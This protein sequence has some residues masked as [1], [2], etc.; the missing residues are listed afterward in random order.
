MSGSFDNPAG[1]AAALSVV[2]PFTLYFIA[3]KNSYSR[4]F[5]GLSA[6][7]IIAAVVLSQSR[8]GVMAL[9]VMCGIWMFAIINVGWLKKWSRKSRFL[10]FGIVAS[11]ILIG[12]YFIKKDSADG[13]LLIWKCTAHMISEKPIM[14][15]GAGGFQREYMLYQASFFKD[16][17]SSKYAIRSDI[18]KHPFNEFLLLLVEHG[19][20]G[21][22]F[23]SLF[24][25]LF[26]REYRK[27]D[28]PEK[29]YAGLCIAGIV[30]FGCFSYLLG[31]PF[32]RLIALF[33][34][35]LIMKDEK[36]LL[37]IPK[38]VLAFL[39]PLMILSCVGLLGVCG[40]IAGVLMS[41]I[42]AP[43]LVGVVIAI[44]SALLT[45]LKQ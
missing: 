31:Y 7:L 38:Q 44:G 20:I 22:M 33:S 30:T 19:I 39:K 41:F 25:F 34:V 4:L 10:A 27:T 21:V 35:A 6:V 5:G 28:S 15:Y 13:R 9:V 23:F 2:F 29:R 24:A 36:S 16:C 40:K 3:K 43:P 42:K 1:F 18:V 11:A 14:G 12:L 32:V 26:I 17:P 37:E 45:I 8:A